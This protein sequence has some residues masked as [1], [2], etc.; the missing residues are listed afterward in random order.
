MILERFG[1]ESAIL[2]LVRLQLEVLK[3]VEGLLDGEVVSRYM[4]M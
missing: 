4:C 2:G 1:S 3:S